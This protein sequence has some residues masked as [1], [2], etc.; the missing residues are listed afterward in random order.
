MKSF[1]GVNELNK[2]RAIE[3]KNTFLIATNLKYIQNTTKRFYLL[4]FCFC[5][6]KF[7]DH[8]EKT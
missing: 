4:T 8:N 1:V 7:P 3:L 6:F 5:F 2:D